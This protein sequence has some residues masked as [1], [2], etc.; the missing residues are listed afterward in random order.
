MQ[1]TFLVLMLLATSIT[2]QAHAEY[3]KVKEVEANI[4]PSNDLHPVH[5]LSTL[6][7][8]ADGFV[9]ELRL[10]FYSLIDFESHNGNYGE[11]VEPY[12]RS[13]HFGSWISETPD[14]WCLNTRAQ[15]LI[16]DSKAEVS[17]NS[18][19]CTVRAGLWSDPYTGQDYTQ[20][21][22]LQIDHVVPLKNAY[23]SGADK[24]N[25]QRRCLYTNYMGNVS[26][27]MPVFGRENSAK[28]DKSPEGYMPPNAA[29]RCEYLAQWLK[30]KL[31]WSLALAP[32]EKDKIMQLADANNCDLQ[33]FKMST[34]ELAT[35]R[36]YIVDN[37]A[38]CQ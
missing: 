12:N 35:Q 11:V 31:I 14:E 30:L 33:A 9:S 23:I 36:Q 10:R 16:R 22:D 32:S 2:R 26:H 37:L 34:S 28:G 25:R 29:Y 17:Y 1:K 38:I 13:K 24:W 21:S 7:N 15:V 4:A 18:S 8:S 27:L 19:G 20:A 3:Y 5:T 6:W